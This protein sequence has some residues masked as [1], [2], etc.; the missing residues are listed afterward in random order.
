[1]KRW[2]IRA[3]VM[4]VA[5]APAVAIVLLLGIYFTEGRFADR[6]Q[7]LRSS[8]MAMARQ[9][10]VAAEYGVFS[11]NRAALDGLAAAM[12][13]E[14]GAVGV[15][16]LDRDGTPLASHG[17]PISNSLHLVVADTSTQTDDDGHVLTTSAPILQGPVA[18]EEFFDAA[19]SPQRA[20]VLGRTAVALSTA[21]LI[22]ERNRL[23]LDSLL[24]T[25]VVL[26]GA[27][28]LALRMGR[29]VT[30]P[31]INLTRT[32][33]KLAR[34]DLR[35]R[36]APDSAGAIRGLENGVNVMAE[37]LKSAT[38]DMERRIAEATAGLAEKTKEAEAANQAKSRFVAVA[39][40]DLRQPLHAIGLYVEALRAHAQSDESRHLVGQIAI[41][42][43]GLQDL[44]HA[45]LDISRL[46][47]GSVQ[48]QLVDFPIDRLLTKMQA[49]Y[50]DAARAKG[51]ALR[52]A[53]SSA[54]VRGD[55]LLLERIL[56][57]LVSNAVRYTRQGKIL[58]GCRRRGNAVHIQ[59]WDTGIGI[60][61]DQQ[62]LIFE[63]FYR[64][65][66]PGLENEKGFGLGLAI[67]ERL[68]RLLGYTLDLRSSEGRGS[69]FVVAVPRAASTGR[70]EEPIEPVHVPS[71][72]HG[73]GV[74]V[75]DDDPQA[76]RATRALL[77]EW[78][79]R[80]WTAASG[81]EAR[82]W[83]AAGD[84]PHVDVIVSDYR[85]PGETGI[86]MLERVRRHLPDVPGIVV[87]AD[88][89][90]AA[91]EAVHGRGYPLLQ[92]PV[93]PAKLRALLEHYLRN[94]NPPPAR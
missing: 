92:K 55:P 87:T 21:S 34:G 81:A 89:S 1:M 3:R 88:S 86:E 73:A 27:I 49:H 41:A 35:A 40:H 54:W 44:I 17:R 19:P 38:E 47:A 94:R 77:E 10:A 58:L 53:P 91:Q 79:C 42:V 2:G 14:Q 93:R 29:D 75:V 45:L 62:R 65:A 18:L 11:G 28:A 78:G 9:L 70:V 61:S 33:E 68:A 57:N 30:R 4:L 63:E 25:L 20:T 67:V 90:D 48:P 36:V 60:P 83:L 8:G 56:S 43:T 64:G 5:L 31:V 71:S 15:L 72:I 13:R 50:C 12:T 22:E 26:I 76:L 7:A 37:A 24:I 74:L 82:A 52:V 6:E 51:I 84:S 69:V 66:A 85:M 32:V 80:V 39:S 16:I 46:D 59:V 23:I